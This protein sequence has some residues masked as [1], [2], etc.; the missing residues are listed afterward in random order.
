MERKLLERDIE[1]TVLSFP[2]HSDGE[3]KE[4]KMEPTQSIAHG[5]TLTHQNSKGKKLHWTHPIECHI[6]IVTKSWSKAQ[7]FN[8]SQQYQLPKREKKWAHHQK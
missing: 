2:H 6:L 7:H 3:L 1:S 4:R 8:P 5:S